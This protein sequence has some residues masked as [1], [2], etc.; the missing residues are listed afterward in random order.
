MLTNGNEIKMV[1]SVGCFD[2]LVGCKFKVVNVENGVV[3]LRSGLGIGCMSEDE[4]KK[5]FVMVRKWTKWIHTV[6][7][8]AYKTDNKKYVKVKKDGI[9]VKASCHPNDVFDL[10]TG[11]KICLEKIEEK[12][13]LNVDG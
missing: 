1:S 9:K 3:S 10:K 13:K 12:M 4:F 7:F 8:Y 11:I 6:N 2:C 5:H